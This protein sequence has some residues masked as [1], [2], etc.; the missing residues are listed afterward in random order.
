VVTSDGG[1][2]R[3]GWETWAWDESLFAGTAVHYVQGRPPYS[4]A[5]AEAVA[6]AVDLDG[7]ARLLD[8]GCGPGVIALRLAGLFDGVVGLDP[9]AA[10]LDEA[11]RA[12]GEQH[13]EN[14]SWVRMRAEDLP[15]DLGRFRVI[16]FAQSFHWMDRPRV[17]STTRKMLDRDGAV[18]LINP[19]IDDDPDP[20]RHPL[21]HPPVPTVEI[22]G[23]R[24]AYL[25]PDRRAGQSYRNTSPSGEDAIFRAAGF[26]PAQSYRAPDDR[27]LERTI[28][29]VVAWVFAASYT[30]PPL[31]GDDLPRFERD[32]RRVLAEASPSGLFSVALRDNS[33]RVWRPDTSA[34]R[35]PLHR[36]G[37]AA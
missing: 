16:S 34:E 13:V 33:V 17:A 11:A 24:V 29:D 28:D 26:L 21:A 25:G 15:A 6:A 22:D 1:T 20:A 10:M 36:S 7:D 32:L 14:V 37:R 12:A 2:A 19:L 35:S 4:P 30:A 5:L 27:V 9:D 23:L 3:F 8:V 31:F 18:I